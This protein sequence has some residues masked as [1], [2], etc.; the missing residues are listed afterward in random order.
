[1][2][3]L[4]RVLVRLTLG[5]LVILWAAY[6]VAYFK[7]NDAVL[8]RFISD[9]VEAADRGQFELGHARYPYWAG[10]FSILVNTPAHVV[11]DDFTL[12][13]P[14]GDKVV[15]VPHVE[16]D[17]HL[18]ELVGS[19]AKTALFAGKRFYLTLHFSNATI[20]SGWGV[21]V[22]TRST[23]NSDKS[24]T[25]I[26][27][28]MGARKPKDTNGGA[29]IIKVDDAELGDVG[30]AMASPTPDG[31]LSWWAKADHLHGKVGL[32]YNSDHDLQTADGPYF[33]F[34]IVDASSPTAALQLGD[35]HFPLDGLVA[36]EFGAHGQVRQ[37]LHFA[38]QAKS[39]GA[40]VHASG[41]LVD[42]YSEHPGVRLDLDVEH[43][44]G[45]LALLPAPLST[46]LSGDPRAHITINGPFTAPVI[47]G[48]VHEIDANLEGVPLT[49]GTAKLH[50]VDGVLTL[51]PAAGRVAH[52]QA[53]ADVELEMREPG[54]WSA[55]LG[56]RGVDLAQL[57]HVS[58]S[59]A[60]EL[61][62]SLDA[63]VRLNGNLI[64]HPERIYITRLGGE[65]DRSRP[66]GKLPR[67]LSVTGSGEYTPVLVTM[68]GVS[69][70]GEGVTV[71]ADGTVDPRDG[72][73]SANVRIDAAAGT[74][75][76]ARLGAPAGLHLDAVHAVGRVTGPP[77]RPTLT[78]HAVAN[79]VSYQRR[80][81]TTLEADLS[82]NGGTLIVSNLAGS[83]LG[84]TVTGSAELGLFGND[85]A[86]PRAEPTIRAALVA[87][88]LS[89][90]ALSGWPLLQGDAHVDVNLEGALS[91]PHG[92]ATL[93]LPKLTMQ[94]DAYRDGKLALEFD[95]AGATIRDLTLHRTRGGSLDGKGTIGWNGD[96]ALRLQPR[97]FPLTAIPFV[98][99]VPIPLAGTLS[100][101][102]SVGGTIEHPVPGG[103]LSLVAFKVRDALLGKGDLKLD[104]GG[105]AIHIS[106]RF[107]GNVT[108]DG[109]ITLVPKLALVAHI[110]FVDLE[111]ERFY[112]EIRQLAEVHG[113]AT[114]E[115][116]ITVDSE[117]GL[118]FAQLTLEQLTLTLNSSD[119]N[120]HP[121]SLVV[122]NPKD[123]PVRLSTD[124]KTLTIKRTRLYSAIG[125]FLV[126]GTVG[127]K[128]NDVY[129]R[130][131]IGLELLE[132][133]FR[134]LFEHTHGPANVELRIAGD[135]SKPEINGYVQIG[136]GRGAA[137]LIP[138]G[139]DGHL[140]LKI[141]SGRIDIT[142][143]YVRLSQVVVSTDKDKLAKASGEVTLNDWTPGAIKGEITGEITPALFQWR[144]LD[145]LADA[146]GSL[147]VDVR[148]GGVWTHPQWRGSAE[149]HNVVFRARKL[150]RDLRIDGGTVIFENFDVAIG[151][152][153]TGGKPE[154]CRSLTGLIDEESKIDN[155][156]ARVS[157]GDGW[158]LK[159]L[160][161]WAS[162]R[163]IRYAQP[164]WSVSFSPTIEIFGDG[165]GLTLKGN[166]N[167]VEGRYAQN[168]E[169]L[170][171]VFR[172]K[173]TEVATPFWESSPLLETMRL[174]LRAQSTGS[175]I[176][177]SNI[178]EL[179][180][181]ANLAISGTLSEWHADG[182][183]NIDEGG[184]L[185]PPGARYNFD[186]E[187]GSVRFEET[188]KF[189]T[190][191]PTI[192]LS[193][194]AP[195]IDKYE[196]QHTLTMRL[197]GTAMSPRLELGSLDGWSS[198]TVLLIL[199]GG[200]SPDEIRRAAQ[201]TSAT[202][203]A[204]QQGSATDAMAK[205]LSGATVGQFISD[206]LKRVTGF[207]T[208]NVEFG[209]N[210]F[211]LKLCKRF[212]R[213]F[214]T[215]GQGELGFAG[216]SRF[217]G[218]IELKL[219]DRP[220]EW[221]GIGRVEYLTRGV[222]TLQ[223]SL[224]S[225]RGELRLRFPLG[226]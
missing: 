140:K 157:L 11:G 67:K 214:K 100:G 146:S 90:T 224:T 198:S 109:Y 201:G 225:G 139:L 196:Q 125:E 130:G 106:G 183:I 40:G 192:D 88:G 91:H 24:E 165:N 42:A 204:Q 161:I 14:D 112:P 205:T 108:V 185:K 18:Q 19:L 150:G 170:G 65:L 182:T 99:S 181:S 212:G 44:R 148:I 141:P 167:L 30:F 47:D 21:I 29:V 138:R 16:A 177:K 7:F 104:P 153:K 54:R 26:I 77:L 190:D 155:V 50:F 9:K 72:R 28:A 124:G 94:G 73:L 156:D 136:G 55:T 61:A 95:D 74:P 10:L 200:Q 217:G 179:T 110:R 37:D 97:D 149:V 51:K 221:S 131:T 211:D 216:S 57:P 17:V 35:Y 96:L 135:L 180:L 191:T 25:N 34:R 220:F 76:W 202:V 102:L 164:S 175:L 142:P 66:G 222:E 121:Q 1:M 103:L 93:L 158:S 105:D 46:W 189:P 23:W 36:A 56:L 129:M 86:H 194:T 203:L 163:E 171:M 79:N 118:T 115:A 117:S 127:G 119:E 3:R 120:G 49:H 209:G 206:P 27:A 178:A 22:P 134:G 176:V 137:E 147:K 208:V 215:C 123:Q 226:Y 172:P 59:L 197:S 71:A 210:S 43:G 80:T 111:L 20:P 132:Y 81:L 114:G 5:I 4:F 75:L 64:H 89:L 159:R 38:A 160:D 82:L 126:E 219:S 32:V 12:V 52:G 53:T 101:D 193:A 107:F 144:W 174:D 122:K 15:R 207:D 195:Y 143:Q 152:P 70:A 169:L 223:D 162:G 58:P 60:A 69:A 78:L 85:L 92:S 8:G 145:Q 13:D 6:T 213:Y 83:G 63:H 168:F 184:I 187:R 68:K 154:G 128:K 98:S 62:G 116:A 31:K 48:E 41:A 188:K 186:T 2:R 199:F 218:S 33:F 45:P 113:R 133:F 166:I 39:L 151:C 173:V 87:N 84:A